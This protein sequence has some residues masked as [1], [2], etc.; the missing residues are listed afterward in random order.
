MFNALPRRVELY[1]VERPEIVFWEF[2]EHVR[3]IQ[4]ALD[5]GPEW[6]VA[7]LLAGEAGLRVGEILGLQ[8]GDL[9]L[10][11]H[12]LTVRRQIRRGVEGTP[13]GRRRSRS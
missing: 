8:W 9:D 7:A 10:V 13:K 3:I 11:A 6:Y 2:E 12:N 5:E 4:A 1:K